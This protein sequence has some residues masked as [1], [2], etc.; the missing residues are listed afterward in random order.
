MD[1]YNSMVQSITHAAN[2]KCNCH[3][4]KETVKSVSNAWLVGTIE[5][6]GVVE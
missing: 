3:S 1:Y 5:Q 4:L 6:H 2:M